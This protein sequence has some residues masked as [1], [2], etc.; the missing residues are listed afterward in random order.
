[1]DK[2]FIG[3]DPDVD[4]SGFAYWSGDTLKLRNLKFFDLLQAIKDAVPTL[5]LLEAGWLNKD[6]RHATTKIPFLKGSK[7]SREWRIAVFNCKIGE[8]VG[9]NHQVGM[10]IE[11]FLIYKNIPYE[12]IRPTKHKITEHKVF[13]GFVKHKFG[14]SNQEQRDAAM[15]IRNHSVYLEHLRK[16]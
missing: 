3:I 15:L 8:R 12:L 9:R 16:V 4:K 13:C 7:G 6:S 10:F 11:E 1:M 2:I 14:R 5:V